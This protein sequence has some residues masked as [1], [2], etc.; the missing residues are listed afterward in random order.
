MSSLKKNEV[1]IVNI[2][3]EIQRLEDK[4]F[5]YTI[6]G[7][8]VNKEEFERYVRSKLCLTPLARTPT[9]HTINHHR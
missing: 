3:A 6:D 7:N 9:A 1:N 4:M 2:I 5:N 8:S